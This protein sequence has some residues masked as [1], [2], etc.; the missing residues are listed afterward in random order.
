MKNRFLLTCLTSFAALTGACEAAES[1]SNIGVVNF[2]SCITESKLGKQEQ[3]SF[4]AL[5]KQLST[6]LEDTDKQLVEIN[7]KLN[8][9]EF[10]DGLSPEGED[11]LKN[12]FRM[13]NEE[14]NRYQA[15][16]YQVLNQAN[17]R[18]VQHLSGNIAAAAEKVA[19]DKHLT[20]VVNKEAC[21]FFSPPLE[22]TTLV[23]NEMDRVFEQESKKQG[24]LPVQ[25]AALSVPNA[26]EASKAAPKASEEKA[27]ANAAQ[28]APEAK[29]NVAQ[30]A[31]EAKG[32]TANAAQKTA[33]V[34]PE[35]KTK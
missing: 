28:K 2:A 18:I 26:A 13:L 35:A 20:M 15:Q 33:D 24:Q 32:T 12:K 21:F 14:L 3:A 11:E 17:M 19:K 5:K 7:N 23:I 25:P 9:T 31:P 34:K 16:Y 6:L 10:M 4:E 30:K 27:T 1:P 29:A 8:D 22:V